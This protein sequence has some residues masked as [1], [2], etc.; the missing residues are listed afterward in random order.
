M[1]TAIGDRLSTLAATRREARSTAAEAAAAALRDLIMEGG[2]RPGDRIAE[3]EMLK[4]LEVSRNTLREAFR[5]LAHEKLLE[6]KLNRGVFVRTL[7]VDDII[8][9]YR[10]RRMIELPALAR[11][12]EPHWARMAEQVRLGRK[13]HAEEDWRAVGTANT[14][15]HREIVA[16]AGSPRLDELMS[17]LSAELRLGFLEMG[18]PRTFHE[19]YLHRNGEISAAAAAGDVAG[20]ARLLERYLADAEAEMVAAFRDKT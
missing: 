1:S 2:L 19:G 7:D 16:A 9:L 11:S 15:F 3:E 10:V 14:H 8:D 17:Q 5:L 13:A 4:P 6:H 12:G 18:H 20:A